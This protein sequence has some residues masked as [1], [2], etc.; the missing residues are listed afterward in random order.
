[1]I[2]GSAMMAMRESAPCKIAAGPARAH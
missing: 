1:V 2:G